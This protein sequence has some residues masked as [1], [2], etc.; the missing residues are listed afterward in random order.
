MGADYLA[1]P[2]F[3]KWKCKYEIGKAFGLDTI[4]CP[5]MTRHLHLEHVSPGSIIVE[6]TLGTGLIVGISLLFA[7]ATG[8]VSLNLNIGP[9]TFNYWQISF[10]NHAD[11]S[12][13][14]RACP[15]PETKS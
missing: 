14:I 9:F 1:D 3:F 8:M 11:G 5:N 10:F 7:I 12:Y 13:E 4:Q 15:S 6:V 2:D